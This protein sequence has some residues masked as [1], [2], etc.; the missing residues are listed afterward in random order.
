MVCRMLFWL[1]QPLSHTQAQLSPWWQGKEVLEANK[2]AAVQ[3]AFLGFNSPAPGKD[4]MFFPG[5]KSGLEMWAGHSW[6]GADLSNTLACTSLGNLKKNLLD[7]KQNWVRAKCIFLTY[8]NLKKTQYII[9]FHNE[10]KN[11]SMRQKSGVEWRSSRIIIIQRRILGLKIGSG[12]SSG[13]INLWW[14]QQCSYACCPDRFQGMHGIKTQEIILVVLLPWKLWKESEET[15]RNSKYWRSFS[16]CSGR[17]CIS[18]CGN[19]GTSCSFNQ[20]SL[21]FR[22]QN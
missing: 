19:K 1:L 3:S 11:A 20:I 4:N 21:T 17:F 10:L 5:E 22:L 9:Y 16:W 8:T 2:R 13:L 12:D 14:H 7:I 18:Y 6:W 15:N